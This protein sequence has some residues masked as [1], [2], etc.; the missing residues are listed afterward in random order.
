MLSAAMGW[1]RNCTWQHEQG[2]GRPL[3]QRSTPLI[4]NRQ[5]AD[6]SRVFNYPKRN[7]AEFL[8]QAA[9]PREKERSAAIGDDRLPEFRH[10]RLAM[11]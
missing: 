10:P 11:L 8:R 9:Q 2:R 3:G 5:T 6:C 1:V 7:V 4:A